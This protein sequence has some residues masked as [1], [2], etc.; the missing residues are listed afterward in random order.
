V[1]SKTVVDVKT[2]IAAIE[3]IYR[4]S[5]MQDPAGWLRDVADAASKLC[6][7][8]PTM[9]Y[10]YHEA[11]VG[12]NLQPMFVR[13][14]GEHGAASANAQQAC[15]PA[16]LGKNPDEQHA[17]VD[18]L[19]GS[20]LTT[21][22]WAEL[23]IPLPANENAL[24]LGTHDGGPLRV[25]LIVTKHGA[26]PLA[27]WEKA[28][29][30]RWLAHVATATRLGQREVDIAVH[31]EPP[32]RVDAARHVPPQDRK[33]LSAAMADREKARTLD[34]QAAL[35][36]WSCLVDGEYSLLL[37]VDARDGRRRYAARRNPME[38]R[39]FHQLNMRER[40]I[41]ELTVGGYNA[42]VAAFA[43]GLDEGAVNTVLTRAATNLG[44]P[45]RAELIADAEKLRKT[46]M[47]DP[48]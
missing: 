14:S 43:L 48:R 36:L 47:K 40:Q 21:T 9:A 45:G 23:G 22:T 44:Y 11:E 8:V 31:L 13:S 35:A 41:I 15:T 4:T 39:R 27:V 10:A 20:Q 37:N 42:K 17:L 26:A 2:I 18:A 33:A 30:Q 38:P 6:G 12:P 5:V 1:G 24:W 46:P 25:C 28:V 19:Y 29:L 3:A 34:G 16:R 32:S 7:D